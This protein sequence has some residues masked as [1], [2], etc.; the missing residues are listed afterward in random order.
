MKILC[1]G[2]LHLGA[3]TGYGRTPGDRLDD[4]RHVLGRIGGLAIE[5]QVDLILNVGDTFEGPGVTPEQLDTFA[6]FIEKTNLVGIPVLAITGNGKH[7][8]AMR[9]TTAVDV[10]RHIPGITVSS[11]P[12]LVDVAGITIAT[13]PWVHPGRLVAAENGDVDRDDINVTAARLLVATA[14]GLHEHIPAGRPAILA[15]HGSV[16]GASLPAG[17]PVDDLREPVLDWDALDALGFDAIVAGHIHKSQMLG[18]PFES[19]GETCGFYVGSPL[20]L[21]FGE[22]DIEHGVWILELGDDVFDGAEIEF[23]PVESRPFVTLD[24]DL[25]D[26]PDAE[27]ALPVAVHEGA[28]VRLR[29]RA[30]QA[31]Q[32][33]IDVAQLRAALLDAGA[34]VVKVEPDIVREDRTRV[35]TVTEDLAPLD[36]F[37]MWAVAN[38]IEQELAARAHARMSTLLEAIA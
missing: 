26:D 29:Y 4:Q 38:D 17:L 15:L 32:R 9:D 25:S 2:D 36:A 7:D 19:K 37:T 12:Q 3:G 34:H 11:A 24:V 31:Q 5:H 22:G 1:F 33:R 16:S 27:L 21:N 13:L 6:M 14:R 35:E 10:F 18:L 8:A 28:V 20:P 23:I 30:T